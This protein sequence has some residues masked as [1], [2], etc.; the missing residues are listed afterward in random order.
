MDY[1]SITPHYFDIVVDEMVKL[2]LRVASEGR[3]PRVP[4]NFGDFLPGGARV[5]EQGPIA[6]ILGAGGQPGDAAGGGVVAR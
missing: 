2:A 6:R 5:N 4:Y 3:T 1:Y